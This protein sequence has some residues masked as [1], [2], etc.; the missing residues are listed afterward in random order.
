MSKVI[1]VGSGPAGLTAGI[2]LGRAG[3]EPIL[4][5]GKEPGGPL[6]ITTIVENYPGFSEGIEGCEL[7]VRMRKQAERFGV[8]FAAKEAKEVN[9]KSH[10]FI[11]KTKDKDFEADAVIVATGAAPRKLGFESEKRLVGRGVSYCATC[12]GPLFKN[13]N[14]IVVGGG[15]SAMEEAV[16]LA[17]FA[18]SVIIVH[19]SEI[20]RASKAMQ[21]RTK[22]NPKISWLFNTEV[23]D[24]IGKNRVEKVKLINNKT[25]KES[26]MEIDGI[27]LAIGREP[28]TKI[29]EGQLKMEKGYIVLKPGDC[30]TSAK[31][32]FAAGDCA[33]WK[34]RQAVTAAGQGCSAALEAIRFLEESRF[35]I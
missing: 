15:D 22:N 35:K 28:N 1:I 30:E 7:I 23:K 29:F 21:E 26:E 18:K 10:P 17:K 12:D 25:G 33:D 5:E 13:K 4:I 3:L 19:R 11:V 27:F 32:V 6:A 8:K 9:F 31:G 24:I 34:Y 20:L 2:Y 14:I 16:F